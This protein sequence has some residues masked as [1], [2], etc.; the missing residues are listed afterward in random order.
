M[1]STQWKYYGT[2]EHGHKTHVGLELKYH[3]EID[4]K[5]VKAFCGAELNHYLSGAIPP[6]YQKDDFC[7]M[8]FLPFVKEVILQD[9]MSVQEI[10][11]SSRIS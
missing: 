9:A 11:A 4:L 7:A 3:R 5:Y 6:F 8:C 1:T 10:V 2:S